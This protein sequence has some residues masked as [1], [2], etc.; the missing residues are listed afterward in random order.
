MEQRSA[1]SEPLD[2]RHLVIDPGDAPLKANGLA[3]VARRIAVEHKFAGHAVTLFFLLRQPLQQTEDFS[4]VP[5]RCLP[6]KGL[7]IGDRF[8]RLDKQVIDAL[9]ADASD[10]TI[11]HIHHGRDPMLLPLTAELKRRAVPFAMTIHGRYSHI[12]DESNEVLKPAPALYLRFFERRALESAR[13]VQAVTPAERAIILRVAPSARC[14]LI[15]NAAYS[16]RVD[17]PP[18]PPSRVAPSD[19]FPRFGFCGRYAIEHKGLDLLLKGFAEYR[20]SGGRGSLELV[21]PGPSR[22]ELESLAKSLSIEACCK[23]GGPLF[24]DEKTRRLQSWDYFVLP[25]RF[26]VFPTAGL[27]AALLGLPLIASRLTGFAELLE[28]RRSGFVIDTLSPGAVAKALSLAEKVEP[29]DWTTMSRAA[30]EM[31]LSIGD[32]T[33]IADHLVK[34][35]RRISAA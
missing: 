13:F 21:G 10:R 25:S 18:A 33:L 35:Y 15:F 2:I 23:I 1:A 24:G 6:L 16:S 20:R 27:E 28:S 31:V 17:G 34:L 29:G 9:L 8:V 32:W 5:T 26:D 4:D 11:F 3:I 19:R 12:F 14:E 7:K 30:F 22:E